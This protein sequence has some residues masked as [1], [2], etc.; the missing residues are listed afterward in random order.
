MDNRRYGSTRWN[1]GISCVT[2][3]AKDDL[4]KPIIVTTN[5]LSKGQVI[6][7]RQA[8]TAIYHNHGKSSFATRA[9]VVIIMFDKVFPTLSLKPLSGSDTTFRAANIFTEI[10][11]HVVAS[12]MNGLVVVLLSSLSSIY[13]FIGEWSDLGKLSR[14]EQLHD[15]TAMSRGRL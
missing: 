9:V 6:V 14:D 13:N 10:L 7:M 15:S 8:R 1:T 3:I 11:C 2:L 4:T 12:P 5:K